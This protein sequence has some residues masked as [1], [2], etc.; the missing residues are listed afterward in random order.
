MHEQ[1]RRIAMATLM[2][3][4]SAG[5]QAP[6][7][8]DGGPF[9]HQV[10]SAT[11]ADG[12][13]FVHDGRVLLEHASVPAAIRLA[14]GRIRL[15]YVDASTRPENVNCAESRDD[16]HSFTVLG[17]TIEAAVALQ[18]GRLGDRR[19]APRLLP[20]STTTPGGRR[21]WH[22]HD[23]RG[24]T[25]RSPATACFVDEGSE[26]VF[27]HPGL[28]DP[29]VFW[30]GRE[31]L[32]YV[33]SL[34]DRA[35]VVATSRDGLDFQ[36]VGPASLQSWGTTAAFPTGDGR[37]RMYAFE[38]KT[39]RSVGS[40]VSWDGLAWEQEPGTRLEAEAGYQLTDPFVVPLADGRQRMFYKR[41]RDTR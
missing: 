16:G 6:S 15:Y 7:P 20:V 25:P 22:C 19:V 21:P 37:L 5:A 12:E 10:L 2:V 35:T 39:Q 3:A 8:G 13:T 38:Q 40:F 18:G 14:D 17:C 4:S 31:W 36:Y 9:H 30:T 41:S 32:M 1:A 34:T 23:A 33:F 29:D 27:Q 26:T 24:S 11:S 28:V